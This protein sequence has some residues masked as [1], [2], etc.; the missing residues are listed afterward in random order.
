MSIHI[1]Y[2]SGSG[3]FSQESAVSDSHHQARLGSC[4]SVW[5]CCLHVGWI[6]PSVSAPLFVPLVPL[7]RNSSGLKFWRWVGG[8]TPQSGTMPNLWICSQQVLPPFCWMFQ[9][10]SS[11]WG[12]ERLLL[13]WH[14]GVSCCYPQFPIPHCYT[15]LFNI[16][17]LFTTLPLPSIPD[18]SLLFSLPLFS[19]SQVPPTLYFP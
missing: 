12:P 15:P 6:F 1:C 9:L 5:V 7:D 16:L 4:N 19:Y 11:T 13:S 14:L 3:R 18:S 17:T 10:M 2:W 8:P